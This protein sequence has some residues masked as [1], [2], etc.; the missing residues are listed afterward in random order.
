MEFK[1]KFLLSLLFITNLLN[2]S[3]LLDGSSICIEDYFMKNGNTYILKSSTMQWESTSENNLIKTI[4]PNYIY[5]KDINRCVPDISIKM[6]L[7]VE[8]FNFLLALTGLIFGGIFMFFT[9]QIFISV[10]GRR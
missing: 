10:G 1:M 3:M 4:I 5:K 7:T 2:A 8:Q 6:G 9:T